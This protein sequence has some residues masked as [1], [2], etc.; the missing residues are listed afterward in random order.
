M[1]N[2]AEFEMDSILLDLMAVLNSSNIISIHA[3]C[4]TNHYGKICTMLIK[5]QYK[6]IDGKENQH[7]IYSHLFSTKMKAKRGI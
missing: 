4:I 6:Q 5:V 7:L 3:Q 1:P 2:Q